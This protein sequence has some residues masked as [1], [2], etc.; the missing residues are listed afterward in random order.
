MIYFLT[1]RTDHDPIIYKTP[2]IAVCR[3]LEKVV[4]VLTHKVL[5]FDV[6]ANAKK[7]HQ[8]EL[9]LVQI[10]TKELK[11][12]ID[13]TEPDH[14]KG[15]RQE[16]I[17]CFNLHI[18][19]QHLFLGHNLKYDYNVCTPYGFK[20]PDLFDTMIAEQ[21]YNLGLGLPANYKD[22][23]ERR[24]QK[25]FPEDKEIRKDFM[26]MNKFSK[27]LLKHIMYGAGD[28]GETTDIA[29]IQKN[30]LAESKQAWFVRNVEFP[31]VKLLSE[32]E[33]KGLHLDEVKWQTLI[34]TKKKKRLETAIKLDE[35]IRT[36][37]KGNLKVTGG[38]YSNKR[39]SGEVTQVGLFG[40]DTIIENKNLKNVNYNSSN[41]VESIIG[42]LGFPVPSYVVT[43]DKYVKDK[44]VEKRGQVKES[45]KEEVINTYI[46]AN[47]TIAIR[48]FLECLLEYKGLQK[49]I[50]SYGLKFLHETIVKN[51][52]IEL[53]F[54]NP[55][56]GRV[57]TVLRQCT[58]DNGRLASGEKD[59]GLF[60]IQNLPAEKEV[61]QAFCL[62]QEEIDLGYWISTVD[63]SGAE[64]VIMAALANE[65][66]LYNLAADKIIDGKKVEGDLH[67]PIATKCWRAVYTY[68]KAKLIAK[69]TPVT[70]KDIKLTDEYLFDAIPHQEKE[71]W[72][73]IQDSK[74]KKYILTENLEIEKEISPK[75]DHPN[76]QLRTDFKSMTFGIVYQ[77]QAKKGGETLNIPKDDA[78]VIID[79]VKAE[80]PLVFKMIDQK[81]AQAFRY[82]YVVFNTRSNNRRSFAEVLEILATINQSK[83]SD[84]AIIA[85]VKEKLGFSKASSIAAEAANV[86]ISGTQ[87]DM[88]K[89][90]MVEIRK[91]P[92]YITSKAAMLGSIHDEIVTMHIGK[93]F[94]E[95]IKQ[96]MIE[97]ADR[98]LSIY[99]D[100]I[101][102]G[103]DLQIL[104]SWT[105]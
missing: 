105:K 64:G 29:T 8:T 91:H 15:W 6:E 65:Q 67:S 71:I 85:Y 37:G 26:K 78:Q 96:I 101:R 14:L 3:D 76:K 97:V 28:V 2:K 44:L 89:E 20:L 83:Y 53:G 54:K 87:A 99:S 42:K 98:Y 72:F 93:E 103:A 100:N 60:N 80:F 49:F 55:V 19:P 21:R 81:I 17:D 58:T 27:F 48:P 46:L 62:T 63:W 12:V 75:V 77:L 32:I 73:T 24:L 40:D 69:Y 5:D 43:K 36:L 57:H 39:K 9:L 74:G 10:G 30:L 95:T 79:V 66:K 70:P 25:F 1:K 56:T 45:L 47:P 102:M 7:Y 35:E 13:M 16:V 31:L 23:Y 22:T 38:K 84:E 88:L 104:H 11:V 86:A 61:R 68:R 34:T 33:L 41:E 92:D 82:G 94:G 50:S 4:E 52:K 18:T 90:A 59:E 51:N